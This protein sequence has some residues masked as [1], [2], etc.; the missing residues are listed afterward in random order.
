MRRDLGDGYELDDDR[1]RIDVDA[2][3]AFLTEIYWAH[4]RSRE[5]VADQLASAWRVV[6]VYH[7]DE[8]VGYARAISDGL[9]SAHLLD[10][11]VLPE[12]RGHRLGLELCREICEGGEGRRLRWTLHTRDA[13]GLYRKLGFREPDDRLLERLPL[14]P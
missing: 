3:H 14:D 1:A 13:H 8:Q 2:V 9:T 10:V 5:Q 12:H 11:Y 7:G 4:G 6:G